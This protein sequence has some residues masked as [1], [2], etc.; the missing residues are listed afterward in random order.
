MKKTILFLLIMVF[1]LSTFFGATLTV[2]AKNFTEQYVLGNLATLLLEENGFNV[3][4]RFGLSS[5]VVR[6]G[7]TTG[8]IDLYADYTG[9]AWVTYLDQEEVIT[10]PDELLEKVR[11]LDAENGIVWLDRINANNTYALAIRQEDYKKYGFE[12]LSD[13]VGYWNEHPNEFRVGVDYEFYERPDGFFAF[14]DHYGLDIPESQVSTMQIGLTYEAIA[15][16]KI[17]I[18][19]VFATDPKILRYNLHVLEDDKNFWPYYHISFAIR[20]DVLDEYPEIEEI[21]RPL[22]L[23][24]NQDILIR[25]NYRIDV[26]GVEPEVVARDYLEGLG[27]ID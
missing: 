17:D 11:E 13:L 9:T 7:L 19:M 6:Q 15:N 5:F 23:Y 24:L 10:D 27:L 1:T 8:Q 25:L 3:V 14:A 21:L 2:G 4:K 16:N 22:T 20:K 12:T 26:E 18:A